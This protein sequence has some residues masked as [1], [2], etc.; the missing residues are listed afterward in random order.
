MVET[1]GRVSGP[2]RRLGASLLALGRIRLELLA[3]EV[4]EEKERVAA[5]LLWATLTALLACFG[6]AFVALFVTVALW[7]THP[8]AA[9]GVP[10]ALF[11]GLAV[12]CARRWQGLLADGSTL[13]QSSIAELRRDEAALRPP[14]PP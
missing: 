8:L 7:D 11:I 2:V 9:L 12:Y 4:H 5:L 6:A 13:F 14:A 10:A 3:I 1:S